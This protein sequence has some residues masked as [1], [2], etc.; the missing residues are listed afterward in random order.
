MDIFLQVLQSFQNTAVF[1]TIFKNTFWQSV[2]QNTC[3]VRQHG[4]RTTDPQENYPP[5]L[6]LTLTVAQTLTLTGDQFSSGE[7]VRI[8]FENCMYLKLTRFLYHNLILFSE[9]KNYE[10]ASANVLSKSF[11]SVTQSWDILQFI[12]KKLLG[13]D[14]K[15]LG[16]D[17]D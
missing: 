17:P 1:K 14:L 13:F 12:F 4:S 5:T 6:K 3:W 9:K 16:L 10:K 15:N 11:I 7:I 8:S 2:N